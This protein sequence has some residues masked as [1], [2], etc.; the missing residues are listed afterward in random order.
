MGTYRLCHTISDM[1]HHYRITVH[2]TVIFIFEMKNI[3]L[4][5]QIITIVWTVIFDYFFTFCNYGSVNHNFG[6]TYLKW[7]GITDKYQKTGYRVNSCRVSVC[8]LKCF[9][10]LW[11]TQPWSFRRCGILDCFSIQNLAINKLFTNGIIE[12]VNNLGS[13]YVTTYRLYFDI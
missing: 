12:I 8:P 10:M 1:P 5:K 11:I 9:E 13:N 4:T 3:N 2:R 6:V 7:C